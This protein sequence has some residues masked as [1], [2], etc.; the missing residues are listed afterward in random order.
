MIAKQRTGEKIDVVV[1]S[2][3]NKDESGAVKKVRFDD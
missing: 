1:F 3:L 2:C